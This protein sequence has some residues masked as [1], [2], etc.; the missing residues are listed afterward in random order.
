MVILKDWRALRCFK[1]TALNFDLIS[2]NTWL[3][4]SYYRIK[5]NKGLNYQFISF[6]CIDLIIKSIVQVVKINHYHK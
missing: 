4:Y 6:I 5:E 2:L 3:K 1:R